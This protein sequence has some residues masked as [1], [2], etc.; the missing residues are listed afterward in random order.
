MLQEKPAKIMNSFLGLGQ[1]LSYPP[2]QDTRTNNECNSRPT[3]GTDVQQCPNQPAAEPSASPAVR[4]ELVVCP[5]AE[6]G[7][8]GVRLASV[9][10]APSGA[11]MAGLPRLIAQRLAALKR[12][13]D[14]LQPC[15]LR[16]CCANNLTVTASG[17]IPGAI[18]IMSASHYVTGS[19]VHAGDRVRY[20]GES[21]NIVFVSDGE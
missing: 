21:G 17:G 1:S 11:T 13:V 10:A 18:G 8:R 14:P 3:T 12:K 5:D 19:E 15:R 7:G 2:C 4:S 20:K 16:R 9:P 6:G